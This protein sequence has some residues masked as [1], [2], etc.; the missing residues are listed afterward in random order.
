MLGACLSQMCSTCGPGTP[1][2]LLLA[3]VLL[4]VHDPGSPPAP[5]VPPRSPASL[6]DA[7]VLMSGVRDASGA[8]LV[9]MGPR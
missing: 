4:E 1:A 7:C 3:L 8:M 5:R 9:Q 6:Y 2:A